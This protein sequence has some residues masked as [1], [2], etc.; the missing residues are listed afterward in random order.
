MKDLKE[1][2]ETMSHGGVMLLWIVAVGLIGYG[3][4]SAGL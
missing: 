2:L 4:G 3:L 1:F